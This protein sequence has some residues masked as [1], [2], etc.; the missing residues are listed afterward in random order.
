MDVKKLERT[1]LEPKTLSIEKLVYYDYYHFCH[2]TC[3][4]F[5]DN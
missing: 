2:K 1:C 5:P 3:S 4:S